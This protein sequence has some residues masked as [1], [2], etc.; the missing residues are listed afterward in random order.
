[1]YF[2]YFNKNYYCS[3]DKSYIEMQYC[4]A[5]GVNYYSKNNFCPD[6]G[7]YEKHS[8]YYDEGAFITEIASISAGSTA[9]FFLIIIF[10]II[11]CFCCCKKKDKNQPI[12]VNVP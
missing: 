5:Y 8:A 3:D 7:I 9:A 12:Q 6:S 1:M 2:Y 4:N 10:I 11:C